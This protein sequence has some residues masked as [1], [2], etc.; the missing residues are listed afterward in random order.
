M[1]RPFTLIEV[2]VALMLVT[3]CAIPLLRPHFRIAGKKLAEAKAL[4][5]Q[6]EVDARFATVR[7]QLYENQ[8]PWNAITGGKKRPRIYRD[9]DIQI[10][11]LERHNKNKRAI[12]RLLEITIDD[13]TY[14][15]FV[16]KIDPN[17]RQ[18]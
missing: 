17:K 3:T 1:R 11:Q 14:H 2:L 15:L 9:G 18:S 12:Y 4:K 7:E 6:M 16:E 8:I 13:K 5:R 10:R